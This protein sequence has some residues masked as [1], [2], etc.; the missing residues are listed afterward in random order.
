MEGPFLTALGT[1]GSAIR[2]ESEYPSY[3]NPPLD[4]GPLL[5]YWLAIA[6]LVRHV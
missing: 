4:A 3:V 2:V 5:I 6:I 1:L